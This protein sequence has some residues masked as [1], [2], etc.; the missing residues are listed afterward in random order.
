[1]EITK[2]RLIQLKNSDA[3]SRLREAKAQNVAMLANGATFSRSR[4]GVFPELVKEMFG[5][6]KTFKKHALSVSQ[7]LQMI[8]AEIKRRDGGEAQV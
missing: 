5:Q 1:M 6:R 2:E 7:E 3:Y 8:E 4:H